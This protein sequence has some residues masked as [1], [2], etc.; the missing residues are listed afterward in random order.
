MR[1]TV[2]DSHNDN[3]R[4]R[5]RDNA[6][7]AIACEKCDG[8]HYPCDA[9]PADVSAPEPHPPQEESRACG[10]GSANSAASAHVGAAE[11][12]GAAGQLS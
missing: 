5:K 4:S 9:N 12:D 10:R 8:A 3:G 11:S 6:A 1:S 7:S 2:G